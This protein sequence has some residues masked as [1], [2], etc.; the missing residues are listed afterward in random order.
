MLVMSS[1]PRVI[2]D[3]IALDW[4]LNKHQFNKLGGANAAKLA[5]ETER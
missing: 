2:G 1:I 5:S 4:S 3:L